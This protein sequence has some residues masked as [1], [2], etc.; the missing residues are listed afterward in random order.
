MDSLNISDFVI[1]FFGTHRILVDYMGNNTITWKRL[2]FSGYL[3]HT[4]ILSSLA[5]R[6][7][8]TV[9]SSMYKAMLAS[10]IMEHVAFRSCRAA[11]LS[12]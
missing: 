7:V 5:L 8:I 12:I 9:Q 6:T 4:V 1:C 11:S 10:S 2:I 3:Q